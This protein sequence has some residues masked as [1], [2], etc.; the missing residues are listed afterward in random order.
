MMNAV[1]RTLLKTLG[2]FKNPLA[3]LWQKIEKKWFFLRK[4]VPPV[5]ASA[6]IEGRFD[7]PF[8]TFRQMSNIFFFKFQKY[9]KFSESSRKVCHQISTQDTLNAVSITGQKKPSP[10][11]DFCWS[12]LISF[13]KLLTFV[14]KKYCLSKFFSWHEWGSV[15]NSVENFSR[16][17]KNQFT[18]ISKQKP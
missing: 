4:F 10:W 5:S 15:D 14:I 7:N 6:H 13:S 11:K 18:Q 2:K 9:F 8:K 3:K 1:L 12:K 16:K 17:V